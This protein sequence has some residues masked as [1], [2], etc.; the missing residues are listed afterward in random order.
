MIL[1][2]M[3]D[4]HLSISFFV[5]GVADLFWLDHVRQKNRGIRLSC[6]PFRGKCDDDPNPLERLPNL[7]P[8][9]FS[10]IYRRIFA[11]HSTTEH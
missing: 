3:L 11:A 9:P 2:P 7:Y 4:C 5:I 8:S 10:N 6:S 1:S